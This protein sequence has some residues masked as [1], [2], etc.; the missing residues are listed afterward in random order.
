MPVLYYYQ[1][2]KQSYSTL[3]EALLSLIPRL[4]SPTLDSLA[5]DLYAGRSDSVFVNPI[6]QSVLEV[7]LSKMVEQGDVNLIVREGSLLPREYMIHHVPPAAKKS[8][9]ILRFPNQIETPQVEFT[10]QVPKAI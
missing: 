9:S 7:T 4:E 10:Y 8:S 6:S 3:P 1:G 5:N 2:R